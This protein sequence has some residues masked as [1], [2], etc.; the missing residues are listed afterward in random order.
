MSQIQLR[1]HALRRRYDRE[2]DLYQWFHGSKFCCG[3]LE[4]IIALHGREEVEVKVRGPGEA[5]RAC[6][7]FLEEILGII[8]QVECS[9]SFRRFFVFCQFRRFLSKM[10]NIATNWRIFLLQVLLEMSPGLPIDKYILHSGHL[11]GHR[12]R[13]ARW[14]PRDTMDVLHKR[15]WD[16]T[17]ATKSED[18]ISLSDLLCFGSAEVK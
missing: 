2:T 5:G 14:S 11:A 18:D 1:R 6:F 15:G 9:A 4:A 13:V 3:P 16:G 7:F 8:D 10:K 12:E 17:V